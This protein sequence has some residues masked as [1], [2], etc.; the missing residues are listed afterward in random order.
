MVS[1]KNKRW[2]VSLGAT[3]VVAVFGSLL[4][5]SCKPKSQPT[6]PTASASGSAAPGAPVLQGA[7]QDYVNR[8][9]EKAGKT[10]QTCKEVTN[11]ADMLSPAACA[12][13]KKDV[14]FS[15][16][17]LDEK[18]K[19]CNDLTDRLCKELG[20]ETKTCNMVRTQTKNF[21]PEKCTTMLGKYQEVLAELKQME[22]Q[23]K[24]LSAEKQAAIS[25]DDAPSFGPATAKVTIVE[26]S[27]FQCP[28]CT[29]AATSVHKVKE[30]YGDKVRY[31]FRQF[32]LNFH[33][34]AA[35]AAE[36]SL[37]AHAQGKFW[38]MHEIMFK[39]TSKLDRAGLEAHAAS[40]GL[41]MDK[42]KKALDSKEFKPRV[43]ADLALG[44]D[45][46][47]KGTPSMFMN[48]KRVENPTDFEA[49]S[50]EIEKLL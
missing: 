15:L 50:K 19:A 40:I 25:K 42:F 45:V 47:V 12:A 41:D 43:D 33:K 30:K 31:L 13:L 18:R 2:L 26:F 27:D 24:P 28:Y 46:G 9:C 29:R 38:E 7:C 16:K 48:G 14:A 37:A 32:P 44:K 1:N 6:P 39:N 36:A 49:L 20:Q 11:T 10:S 34:N 23:N 4:A 22:D 35:G 8:V 21:P 17:R 5:A 3:L